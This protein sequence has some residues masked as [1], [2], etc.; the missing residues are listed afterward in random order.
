VLVLSQFPKE[1]YPLELIGDDAA[2]VGCLPKMRVADVDSFLGSVRRVAAGGSALD[3]DVVA[4]MVSRRRRDDPLESL[5]PRE[6]EMLA[7]MAQGKSNHGIAQELTVTPAAVEKHITSVFGKLGLGAEPRSHRRVMVVLALLRQQR[8]ALAQLGVLTAVL[9]R[10]L[11]LGRV[12]DAVA[13]GRL[14]R[15]APLLLALLAR[16]LDREIDPLL[17][18]VPFVHAGSL[19]RPGE[20]NLRLDA[21]GTAGRAVHGQRAAGGVDAVGQPAAL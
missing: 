1:R 21:R 9:A 15:L 13:L 18:L 14:G 12:T 5:A 4:L 20:G 19:P 11:A 16:L 7:L 6:R 3:P 10:S 2:A 17:E 8:S